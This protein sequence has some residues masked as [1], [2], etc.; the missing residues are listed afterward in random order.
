MYTSHVF[1]NKNLHRES[2]MQELRKTS[3][4]VLYW[5]GVCITNNIL[6][7]SCKLSVKS[8][9]ASSDGTKSVK[10]LAVV[11]SSRPEVRTSWTKSFPPTS[12]AVSSRLFRLTARQVMNLFLIILPSIYTWFNY[13][14]VSW[15]SSNVHLN[16]WIQHTDT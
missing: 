3:W 4:P 9:T 6:T 11:F 7:A 10:L 16:H 8:R 14:H 2:N 5:C 1:L 15:F 12:A 13:L